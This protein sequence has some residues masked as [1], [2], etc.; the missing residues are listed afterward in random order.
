MRDVLQEW[1]AYIPQTFPHYTRHTTGHSESIIRCISSLLFDQGDY[2]KPT[3]KLSAIEAY[4]LVAAA[5]L[6]D[7]GMVCSDAE[8]I[9]ILESDEWKGWVSAG[10][11]AEW[12]KLIEKLRTD[13][14]KLEPSVRHFLADVQMRFLISEFV[15]QRHHIRSERLAAQAEEAFG[16]FA[17]DDRELLR[18]IGDVC[19]GHG[20]TSNQLLD[21]ERFPEERDI[22]GEKANVRFLAIAF[23][24]GDL[25]DMGSDRACPILLNAANPLPRES[26][27]HWSQYRAIT[28]RRI[29]PK[30]I[31]ISASCNT[32]EEFQVL[33]GWCRWIVDEAAFAAKIMPNAARHQRWLP[34]EAKME[35]GSGQ[36]IK[37]GPSPNA[38]FVPVQ[39]RF[40]LE[41]NSVVRLLVH[42]LYGNPLSFIRELLQ[43]AVDASRVAMCAD[44]LQSGQSVPRVLADVDETL[45]AKFP[46]TIG[47]DTRPTTSMRTDS[48][49]GHDV[50]YVEDRGT[51]MD[52]S[53]I[54][55]F[56]LQVGRS[57][58]VSAEFEKRFTFT[59][60]SHFG[61]GF[62]SVFSASDHVEIDTFKGDSESAIHLT[63]G[64]PQSYFVVE[65]GTRRS[66]GT[67][68][69]VTLNRKIEPT[70]FHQ[71]LT[72]WCR[73]VEIAVR[74]EVDGVEIEVLNAE[75]RQQHEREVADVE[76][77][78]AVL[79]V[80]SFDVKEETTRGAVY[81]IERDGKDGKR[82]DLHHW[83]QY[84]YPKANPN[85]ELI[86]LPG[87]VTCFNGIS[88]SREGS[89]LRQGFTYRLDL[90][91]RADLPALSREDVAHVHM[92][93]TQRAPAAVWAVLRAALQDHLAT[94]Q[95]VGKGG[96]RYKQ[97]LA[98]DFSVP[99]YWE[100]VPACFPVY[101][102]GESALLSIDE[103]NS[104]SRIRVLCRVNNKRTSYQAVVDQAKVLSRDIREPIILGSDLRAMSVELRAVILKARGINWAT[105]SS[106]VVEIA[107]EKGTSNLQLPLRRYGSPGRVV[108][109]T[110][111]NL[112]GLAA[113]ASGED[114]DAVCVLNETHVITKW[115]REVVNAAKNGTTPIIP[116]HVTQIGDLL[117][118][119]LEY[120]GYGYHGEQ[121][122]SYLKRWRETM[123]F[124]G[125][126]H[127]PD[128]QP[129]E[130]VE[131][132]E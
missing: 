77:D 68:I 60:S 94:S 4:V 51:G 52:R 64:G 39:W 109:I 12:L 111:C 123:P 3:L 82:W 11:P 33:Q 80:R 83:S 31:E 44:L 78:G 27:P 92:G 126:L 129:T 49:A 105:L 30:R 122:I 95:Y 14:S 74:V 41:P 88:V 81:L 124:V 50:L 96:W 112:V 25:L 16:R 121:L 87:T 32:R 18:T 9:A 6:H 53:I 72:H 8:K 24:L 99:R 21:D 86:E 97:R 57:Y 48:S 79:R 93:E 1:L 116:A 117:K 62:L 130:I 73:M 132:C 42:N 22:R 127:P 71:S 90:R 104:N 59:P 46:V 108:S 19:L 55:K 45:R 113:H 98:A 63:L 2:R 114:L 34:P 56:F 120:G 58:Y 75:R 100:T 65:K 7:A 61:V 119:A 36:S 84:Q 101:F 43:N 13:A 54:E 23:R 10:P 38:K 15:R 131:R 20:L 66:R 103:L 5:Y 17:F 89:Y 35:A 67:R 76:E 102:S 28:H 69:E 125:G 128:M 110:N 70:L 107:W 47:L 118:T 85:A 29:S 91:S 106:G 26:L 115:F 40:E 37:I